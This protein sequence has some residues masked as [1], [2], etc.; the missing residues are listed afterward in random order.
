MSLIPGRVVIFADFFAVMF[1]LRYEDGMSRKNG[2]RNV[3]VG[4]MVAVGT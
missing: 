2:G 4:T 3:R 1:T